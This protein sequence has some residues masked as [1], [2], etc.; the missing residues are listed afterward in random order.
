[1]TPIRLFKVGIAKV[2]L[3]QSTCEKYTAGSQPAL[4]RT[5][6]HSLGKA[7]PVTM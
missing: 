7:L 2:L 6:L 1:M 4:G 5:L 3:T